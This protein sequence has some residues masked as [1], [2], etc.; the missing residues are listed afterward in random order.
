ME[1][2]NIAA[3]D[4]YELS[5]LFGSAAGRCQGSVII[6]SAT[7][8]RKEFYINFASFLNENG[9]NVLLFDYRGIG[10]SAPNDLK[11]ANFFMH[12]WGTFDMNAALNYLVYEKKLTNIIRVGHSIGGQLVGFIENP[13][14]PQENCYRQCRS[15]LLGLLSISDEHRDVG[16][17]AFGQP[18]YS[19]VVWIW[20]D[21]QDWVGRRPAKKHN[22]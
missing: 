9:Y 3:S 14:T 18:C 13:T 19:Q 12:E 11:S 5:A 17:V 8:I 16:D 2:I 20:Y 21:A 4:G 7:S 6:S 22:S 10:G 15:W 1:S